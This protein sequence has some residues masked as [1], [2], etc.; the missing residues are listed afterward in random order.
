MAKS[1]YQ[2][3]R[4]VYQQKRAIYQHKRAIYRLSKGRLWTNLDDL[5][6]RVFHAEVQVHEVVLGVVVMHVPGTAVLG[7]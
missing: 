6:L 1:R 4:A 5:A 3:K 2:P 7:G